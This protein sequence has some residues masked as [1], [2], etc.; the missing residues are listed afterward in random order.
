MPG[1]L[2]GKVALITGGGTGIGLATAREFAREG[3]QVYITGRRKPELDAAA[4]S[5]GSG[6]TAIQGDVTKLKDSELCEAMRKM[7]PEQRVAHV[8]EM[9]EKRRALQKQI[10]ELTAQRNAYVAKE[11]K[12]QQGKAGQALDAAIRETLRI[13]AAQRGIHIPDAEPAKGGKSE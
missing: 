12:R 11:M 1:K 2:D 9:T 3:A 13:Q 5:I 7:T 8:K 4:A 6:V 10:N